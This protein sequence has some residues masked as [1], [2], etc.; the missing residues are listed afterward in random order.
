MFGMFPSLA[1]PAAPPAA[2]PALYRLRGG[3]W[4]GWT[5]G[6]VAAQQGG[7]AYLVSLLGRE[8][9]AVPDEAKAAIRAVLGLPAPEADA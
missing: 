6:A 4:Q 8:R 1:P 3:I 2:D 9:A 7:P 5:V